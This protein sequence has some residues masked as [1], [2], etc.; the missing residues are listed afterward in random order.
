[1]RIQERYQSSFSRRL[2]DVDG[3]SDTALLKELY[4]SDSQGVIRLF[5]SQ[6]SLHSNPAALSE[7]IKA[8][9]SVDRLDGSELLR[10]LQ[11]GLDELLHRI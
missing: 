5:E 8:L 2:R 6:P 7:Y 10:T 3:A 9:V 1:M 4:R 11:R